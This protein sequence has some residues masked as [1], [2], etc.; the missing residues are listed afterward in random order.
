MLPDLEGVSISNGG[1]SPKGMQML[2]DGLPR[3][4]MVID[5]QPLGYSIPRGTT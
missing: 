5:P 4:E 1:L 2:T 3:V